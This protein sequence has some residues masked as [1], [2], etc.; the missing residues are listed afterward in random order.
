ME[1]PVTIQEAVAGEMPNVSVTSGSAR[2]NM[3]VFIMTRTTAIL[4]RRVSSPSFGR[5]ASTE[6]PSFSAA[7]EI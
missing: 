4:N 3:A 1:Y 6:E 2:L 7:A 5:V